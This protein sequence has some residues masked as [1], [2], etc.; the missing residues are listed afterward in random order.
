MERDVLSYRA[1]AR[2]KMRDTTAILA[3][4]RFSVFF[5]LKGFFK[6]C[7]MSTR[8]IP[9]WVRLLE[10]IAKEAKKEDRN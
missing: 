10:E 6:T 2:V 7:I 9:N 5:A 8:E 4:R 3:L 1:I